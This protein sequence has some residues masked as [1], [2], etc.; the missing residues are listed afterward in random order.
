MPEAFWSALSD[1]NRRAV[2]ALLCDRP[3]DVGELVD[4]LGVSQPTVSK[5][6]R[7]LREAGLVQVQGVAQRRV[8]S[9]EPG[10]FAELDAWLEPF[11]RRW[12]ERLD[13][14][15]RHLDAD[16]AHREI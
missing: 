10:P 9:L 8:Y 14:L 13:A 6:L 2:L 5:H 1:P 3:R 12:N 15:G 4:A 16:D 7:V 11:R